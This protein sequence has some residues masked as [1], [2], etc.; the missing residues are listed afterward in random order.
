M[1]VSAPRCAPARRFRFDR[2][3]VDEAGAR[4]VVEERPR[5]CSQRA[6]RLLVL[7]CENPGRTLSRQELLDRLWPGGQIVG[8]E[9]LTQAVFRAR[10]CLGRHADRIVTVR[11]IGFRL[12]AEVSVDDEPDSL[13]GVPPPLRLVD[14]GPTGVASDMTM[15]ALDDDRPAPAPDTT[16]TPAPTADSARLRRRVLGMALGA[17]ALL[18]ALVAALMLRA[19]ASDGE[20]IDEGF[21][22]H[23]GDLHTERQASHALI[24]EAFRR[25][26]AGDRPRARALLE[27][28]HASD[29]STPVPALFL[30]LWSIGGG[31]LADAQDWIG[32]AARRLDDVREP[33]LRAL[34]AYVRAEAGD[35]SHEVLRHAG[36]V[37]DM[38]PL[39]W[40]LRLARAHLLQYEGFRDAA[41]AELAAIDVGDLGHRKLVMALA[42][43]ASLGDADGA[44]AVAG[45][46]AARLP[47]RAELD[48]L[49]GRIAW[50]HGDLVAARAAWTE[51]VA[52][53]EGEARFDLANRSLANLGAIDVVDGRFDE[54]IDRFERA[55]TGMAD[56]GWRTDVVDLSMMLAEL[57]ALAGHADAMHDALARAQSVA[58]DRVGGH[59]AGLVV[60]QRARLLGAHGADPGHPREVALLLASDAA[61]HAGDLDAARQAWHDAAR[62]IAPSSALRDELR[63]RAQR[64]GLPMPDAMPVDPPYPPLSRLTTRAV[65]AAEAGR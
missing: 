41:R 60:L 38:R 7:L 55:R 58:A 6:L 56:S 2:V 5:A 11:G 47:A 1:S 27:T 33:Y 54:A 63:V 23:A 42:D 53:A 14:T 50:S 57:H 64:L 24:R 45:A 25:E 59:L 3:V 19:P 13:R 34:L 21:A 22:L 40:Q 51:A 35:S 18:L 4:L 26:A 39:A 28:V 48:Y 31:N 20:L 12:D 37:L 9:A 16:A 62:L 30:A 10:A 8:D 15:P 43:R 29:A 17:A 46:L 36:A 65:I 61:L 44:A 49:R 52:R 32:Q